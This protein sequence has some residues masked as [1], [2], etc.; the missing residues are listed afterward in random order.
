MADPLVQKVIS[1]ILR[2]TGSSSGD[3]SKADS[4]YNPAFGQNAD[5]GDRKNILPDEYPVARNP[6]QP[7][8]PGAGPKV[9]PGLIQVQVRGRG[10]PSPL[11]KKAPA[12]SPAEHSYQVAGGGRRREEVIGTARGGTIGLVSPNLERSLR[13]KMGI[14]ERYHAIGVLSSRLGAAPQIM[15]A[16]EAVKATNS[17]VLTIQMARDGLGGPGHGVYILFGGADVADVIRAVQI[18]LAAVDHYFAEVIS[19]DV[20]AVEVHHTARAAGALAMAFDAVPDQAFGILIGAPAGVGLL[21]ADVALKT[22]KV[23]ATHYLGPS[24][25]SAF[26]NEVWLTVSGTPAA[27]RNALDA[28]KT[29]GLGLLEELRR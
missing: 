18:G 7:V 14:D 9:A 25:L 2:Q 15:A 24:S 12:G 20:G 28:A 8:E 16:D 27:V 10:Q 1:E 5:S 29:A 4:G 26:S 6:L 17:R 3:K 23:E 13:A 21:M 11:D 19:S 22:A